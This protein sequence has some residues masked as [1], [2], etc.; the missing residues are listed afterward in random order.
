MRSRTAARCA[1][2]AE[3]CAGYARAVIS[4]RTWGSTKL[5]PGAHP[6]LTL[7]QP[8]TARGRM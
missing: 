4:T 8:H 1:G 2:S 7:R 3:T 5:V 6:Y